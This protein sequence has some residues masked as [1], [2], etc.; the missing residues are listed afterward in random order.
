MEGAIHIQLP[1]DRPWAAPLRA[2]LGELGLGYEPVLGELELQA[3]DLLA[4]LQELG[5]VKFEELP[6]AWYFR[7]TSTTGSVEDD[8]STLVV[9]GTQVTGFGG[10]FLFA[11]GE[12][13]Y[14]AAVVGSGRNTF[15][16]VA[17]PSLKDLAGLVR[18][19]Q[20]AVAASR[21]KHLQVY[22]GEGYG[23][24]HRRPGGVRED[25]LILPERMKRDLL[26]YVDAFARGAED[27]AIGHSTR[28]VL[29]LGRAGT[30]KTMTAR[31]ILHRLGGF[32]KYLFV[33]A[34]AAS[35]PF[36]ARNFEQMVHAID[37]GSEPAIVVIE[38]LDRMFEG[39]A[40]TPQ[41]FLNVLDG[42]LEP[43]VPVLWL[44]TSNDPG[45]IAQNLT[46]RLVASTGFSCSR[47]R[48]YYNVLGFSNY[49]PRKISM[50]NC[51]DPWPKPPTDS[52]ALISERSAEAPSSAGI[53]T[54]CPT[55]TRSGSSSSG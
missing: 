4:A 25:H 50:D 48:T 54:P 2:R 33:R 43:R 39:G 36:D 17:A 1:A 21:R 46:D 45:D 11:L 13:R 26:A 31:H 35:G 40:T 9:Q 14:G 23:L 34:T 7:V 37:G 55:E 30:G 53:P 19:I 6:I 15:T 12:M 44:A 8:R 52:R 18:R 32:R 20:Q 47:C 16:V 10:A 24:S 28:G 27:G 29:F 41:Y 38:D 5:V 3:A 49:T 22:G 42:L 51:R